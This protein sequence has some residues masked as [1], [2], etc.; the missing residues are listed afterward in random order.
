M[1]TSFAISTIRIMEAIKIIA[2][3]SIVDSIS[4]AEVTNFGNFLQISFV[5]AVKVVV[6]SIIIIIEE[7][8][9]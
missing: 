4:T 1:I 5:V 2:V 8:K 3:I 6:N 7:A 9:D